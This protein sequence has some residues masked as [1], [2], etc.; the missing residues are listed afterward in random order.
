M[1]CHQVLAIEHRLIFA[2]DNT[3][4]SLTVFASLFTFDWSRFNDFC[5]RQDA[6][7]SRE[8]GCIDLT[9]TSKNNKAVN[10]RRATFI[11]LV[12][13]RNRVNEVS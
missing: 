2:N 4:C 1:N 7:C 6:V 5:A 12:W 10:H 9:G 8:N 11:Q 13:V 3:S